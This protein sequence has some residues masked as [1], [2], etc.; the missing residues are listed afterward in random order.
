MIRKPLFVALACIAF[1]STAFAQGGGGGGG[2][3][4][5][6]GGGAGGGAGF[7]GKLWC[8]DR[9]LVEQRD[10]GPLGSFRHRDSRH[11]HRR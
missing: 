9:H 11:H 3:G 2:G 6:S 8:W 4:G 10:L 7:G 1:S 5:G